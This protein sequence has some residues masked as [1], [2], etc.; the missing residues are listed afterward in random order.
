[1]IT[2]TLPRSPGYQAGYIAATGNPLAAITW[3]AAY[4]TED[5][6]FVAPAD[7]GN[8]TSWP[9]YSGNGRTMTSFNVAPTFTTSNTAIGNRPTINCDE[10]V[11]QAMRTSVSITQAQTFSV[12]AVCAN[13]SAATVPN[14]GALLGSDSS[15]GP[16]ILAGTTSVAGIFAGTAIARSSPTQPST[17]AHLWTFVV[18]GAASKIVK[19]GTSGTVT[20]TPG[21]VGYSALQLALCNRGGVE[22]AGAGL[23]GTAQV[24][25]LGLYN[26]DVTLDANYNRLKAY[27]ASHYALT[28]A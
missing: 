27:V 12:V 9:D 24:A 6:A 22:N 17:G 20:A 8:V 28:I 14:Q 1:M 19:D 11:K 15:A 7:G 13:W 3:A 5:P 25:F 26:G 21:V 4:W 18:A 2:Q 16:Q 10:G 23:F